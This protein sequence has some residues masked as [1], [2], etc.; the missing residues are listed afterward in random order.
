MQLNLKKNPL[1][2]YLK[3][4]PILLLWGNLSHAQRQR[5]DTS[6]YR[7][8]PIPA[9]LMPI[10]RAAGSSSL[11]STYFYGGKRLSS[12]YS[13]EVPFYEIGDPTVSHHFAVFR[14]MT[15]LTRL[16]AL[17]PL[18]YILLKQNQNKG[19][20]WTFYGGSI[21]ASL[22]FTIIGNSQINKA[23]TRYNELLRQPRVGLSVA[24]VLLTGRVAVGA[25]MTWQF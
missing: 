24:P 15:T 19:T 10:E 13:L 1:K 7:T 11:G 21:V 14:S 4:V 5:D 3:L 20:Y 23:V 2:P 17:L 9:H 8:G 6:H 22:A 12:P 16:T 18:G 25:G